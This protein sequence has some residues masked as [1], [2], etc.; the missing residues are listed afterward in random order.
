MNSRE[1]KDN[2][3]SAKDGIIGGINLSSFSEDANTEYKS[4]ISKYMILLFEESRKIMGLHGSQQV[5]S[6]DVKRA[7]QYLFTYIPPQPHSIWKDILM[8]GGFTFFGISL[9]IQIEIILAQITNN[10][11]SQ[12]LSFVF[13]TV[14]LVM[15]A[16]SFVKYRND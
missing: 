7:S 15:I 2:L 3:Q 11:T 1:D 8:G 9:T 4:S 12:G 6:S 16:I 5:S 13:F 14:G 10:S